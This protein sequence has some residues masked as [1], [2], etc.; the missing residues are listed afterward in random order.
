MQISL[1]SKQKAWIRRRDENQCQLCY[2]KGTQCHHIVSIRE[3]RS[4]KWVSEKVNSPYNVILLCNDCH[5][6]AHIIDFKDLLFLIAEKNT[7]IYK[8]EHPNDTFPF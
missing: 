2:G 4:K 1:T 7:I 3:A 6:E 8:F 5:K